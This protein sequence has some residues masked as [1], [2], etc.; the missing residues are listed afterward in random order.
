MPVSARERALSG[1]D[2]AVRGVTALDGTT[3]ARIER[4]ALAVFARGE[5]DKATTRAIAAEAG[6]SEGALYRHYKSKNDIFTDLFFSIHGELGRLIEN[7]AK[8]NDTVSDR[9]AALVRAYCRTADNDW[10][11]FAF[12]L[13]SMHRFLPGPEG[14]PDPVA[15]AEAIT[16]DAM[17]AGEIAP[18]DPILVTGMALG[19]VLQPALHM[20]YGRL[21]G[22]LS[23][24]EEDLVR[25]VIAVLNPVA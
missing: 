22:P 25:A 1:E 5:M 8:E 12:H 20:A 9:A 17:A 3:K 21:K 24:H 15:A 6:I 16:R 2:E 11:L 7:A 19:A 13:L 18:G 14:E 10:Q 23:A 4:A